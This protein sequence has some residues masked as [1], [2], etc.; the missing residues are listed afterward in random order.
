MNANPRVCADP[1]AAKRKIRTDVMTSR[2]RIEMEGTCGG[3]H[4]AFLD[5]HA[6]KMVRRTQAPPPLPLLEPDKGV[7][8]ERS[9]K[10][11]EAALIF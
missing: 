8:E 3:T 9:T 11:P 10:D 2:M 6:C 7:E 4:T 5:F 1:A